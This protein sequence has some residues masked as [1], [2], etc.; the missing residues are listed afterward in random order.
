M[1]TYESMIVLR[2]NLSSEEATAENKVVLDLIRSHGGEVIETDEWGKR[3]LAYEIERN[4][5]GWYFV[6]Y[7]RMS[8][9]HLLELERHYKISEL[10]LRYNILLKEE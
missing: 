4:Q 9:E 6:N 1:R 5:E 7:F 10:Y 8:Q 2:E 3:R